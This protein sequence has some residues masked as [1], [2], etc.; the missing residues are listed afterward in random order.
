MESKSID[1]AW[2]IELGSNLVDHL[3]EVHECS[4]LPSDVRK[5]CT[6]RRAEGESVTIR[7][8][9]S[10]EGAV[11]GTFYTLD[12]L[13]KLEYSNNLDHVLEYTE[14]LT[15]PVMIVFACFEH[16]RLGLK[17]ES[18][19]FYNKHSNISTVYV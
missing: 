10:K 13:S 5:L 16:I 17:K 7:W 3:K 14:T 6:I 11:S 1:L 19:Y 12:E 8:Y 9:H 15:A 4:D 18:F 2:L